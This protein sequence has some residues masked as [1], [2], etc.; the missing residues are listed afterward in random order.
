[1]AM[2]LATVKELFGSKKFL[3]T[4]T[5]VAAILVGKLGWNVD[6][7]TLW[8]MVTVI[9]ACITG[10]GMADFGKAKTQP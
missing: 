8:M 6:E 9:A 10:Q 3:T 1:M 5:G 2:F 4:L 7:E